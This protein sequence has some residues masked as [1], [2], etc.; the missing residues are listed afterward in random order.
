MLELEDA[1]VAIASSR[2]F[3]EKLRWKVVAG[4][5]CQRYLAL[6]TALDVAG[7]EG[8]VHLAQVPRASS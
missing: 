2:G 8:S 1:P 3:W 6:V 4:A 5:S 7:L